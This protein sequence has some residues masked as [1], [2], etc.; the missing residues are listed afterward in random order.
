M[1]TIG[2]D[3]MDI[4]YEYKTQLDDYDTTIINLKML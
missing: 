3:C 1:N 4:I 2:K